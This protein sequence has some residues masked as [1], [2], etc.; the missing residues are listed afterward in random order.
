M[1]GQANNGAARA[2]FSVQSARRKPLFFRAKL[3]IHDVIKHQRR[4]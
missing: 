4:P 1:G 2:S 3:R